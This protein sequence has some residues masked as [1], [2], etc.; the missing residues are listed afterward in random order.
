M[1]EQLK[2]AFE[3]ANYME[4]LA[5]QKHILKEEYNQNLIVYYNGGVFKADQSLITFVKALV[6]FNKGETAVLVD[7][8]SIPVDIQ[9]ADFLEKVL[10]AYHFATNEYYT[11]YTALRNSRTVESLM[12]V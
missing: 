7:S 11:R 12:L 2:K 3:I 4:T 5:S 8:N 10:S 1:S 9:L 6:D